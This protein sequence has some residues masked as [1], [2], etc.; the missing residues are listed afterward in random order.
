MMRGG[1]TAE[2]HR[3]AAQ[4][5]TP[6]RVHGTSHTG[7][8]GTV[9]RCVTFRFSSFNFGVPQSMMTGENWSHTRTAEFRQLL[10]QRGILPSDF[11]LGCEFGGMRQGH[12][13]A[14]N[15]DLDD[16]VQTSL[17]NSDISSEGAYFVIYNTDGRKNITLKERGITALPRGHDVDLF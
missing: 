9:T 17:P 8:D 13:L 1:D 7:A 10:L 16:L 15:V 14:E 12:H 6:T 11:L 2:M 5:E 3:G 4:P